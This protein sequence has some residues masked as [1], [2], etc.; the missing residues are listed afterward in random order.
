MVEA[1][2]AFIHGHPLEALLDL[3]L[4]IFVVFSLTAMVL[5]TLA[6]FNYEPPNRGQSGRGRWKFQWPKSRSNW[7]KLRRIVG[8]FV[9]SFLGLIAVFS[10]CLY[11]VA[12]LHTH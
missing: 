8:I 2:Y 1:I 10:L 12:N 7:P 9:G 11:I 5:G 4:V 3:L 6:F